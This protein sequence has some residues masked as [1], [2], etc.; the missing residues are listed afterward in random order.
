MRPQR[1]FHKPTPASLSGVLAV[2]RAFEG[3]LIALLGLMLVPLGP[4]TE[5]DVY[6]PVKVVSLPGWIEDI[7]I[8][9]VRPL[10]YLSARYNNAVLVFSL[11][12][13]EVEGTIALG[14]SPAKLD[15]DPR[16]DRLYVALTNGPGVAVV[17]LSSRV[18]ETTWPVGGVFDVD[19][20]R[21]D[22]LAAT[23]GCDSFVAGNYLLNSTTGAVIAP[24]FSTPQL[25]CDMAVEASDDGSSFYVAELGLCSSTLF[26]ISV[27]T[28]VPIEELQ[29]PTCY[30]ED[31]VLSP[32]GDRLYTGSS[33][34]RALRTSDLSVAAEF[35]IEGALGGTA[36]VAVSRDG[37]SVLGD[38]RDTFNPS[39]VTFDATSFEPVDRLRASRVVRLYEVA[40]DGTTVIAYTT[41]QTVHRLEVFSTLAPPNRPPVPSFSATPDTV[42]VDQRVEF[43]SS[44][45]DPE[46]GV[47][48]YEWRFGDGGASTAPT[49]LHEYSL[50]GIYNVSLTVVDDTFQSA[51]TWRNVTV[52]APP[53]PVASLALDSDPPFV[54]GLVVMFDA[55]ASSAPAN[56]IRVFDW[57]FGDGSTIRMPGN[58]PRIGHGFQAGGT[59]EVRLTVTN[60]RGLSDS[61]SLSIDVAW[62]YPPTFENHTDRS[63]FRIP[64]PS[65]WFLERG[66]VPED[67]E[68]V[69]IGPTY[70]NFRTNVLVDVVNDTHVKETPQ[71][72]ETQLQSLI[73]E[74]RRTQPSATMEGK[75]DALTVDGRL[76][77]TFEIQYGPLPFAQRVAVV[78]SDFHDRAWVI[79]LSLEEKRLAFWRPHFDYMVMGFRILLP[80]AGD[81]TGNGNGT[82]TGDGTGSEPGG[83]FSIWLAVLAAILA[84]AVVGGLLA[85][86]VRRVRRPPAGDPMTPGES[87]PAEFTGG[88]SGGTPPNPP[89]T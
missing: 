43:S 57:D 32:T 56:W 15:A 3:F 78:V 47:L 84:G 41:D 16:T 33:P 59:F 54:V 76:A 75:S 85:W 42:Y 29:A 89:E 61:A 1:S 48:F 37:F 4:G 40:Q 50:P 58:E 79:V 53:P 9:P 88:D 49:A 77:M 65:G 38:N 87:D 6:T 80:G 21:A 73:E 23:A 66:T 72:L 31:I 30:V 83:G 45:Y 18:V 74:L 67:P 39:I 34:I 2:G 86:R 82:G 63:G 10:A 7:E 14:G 24:L 64:L 8:D 68:V 5:A 60:D 36:S 22:R 25:A 55:S 71:Y 11:D 12:T 17:N 26:K 51:S 46:G 52:L 28:G 35:P 20:G 69:A 81:G 27:A 70:E 44:S 62:D 19:A 13:L